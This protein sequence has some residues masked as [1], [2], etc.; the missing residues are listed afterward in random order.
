MG[1]S[2]AGGR[3]V[4][5]SDAQAG[6]CV[7]VIWSVAKTQIAGPHPPAFP[8]QYN[9]DLLRLC[10]SNQFPGD[11]M[12]LIV[13]SLLRVS[14]LDQN[15]SCGVKRNCRPCM[16]LMCRWSRGTDASPEGGLSPGQRVGGVRTPGW[17]A[18]LPRA[19]SHT[20]RCVVQ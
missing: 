8:T 9:W 3:G 18:A 7:T 5:G 10:I 1:W 17:P 6:V 16:S 20:P 15:E 11:V 2:T 19:P 4:P 13:R 12:L 14:V